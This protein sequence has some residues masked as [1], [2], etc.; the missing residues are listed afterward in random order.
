MI[1]RPF[2]DGGK[3]E[4]VEEQLDFL[5]VLSVDKAVD[6]V[7]AGDVDGVMVRVVGA[8]HRA[9]RLTLTQHHLVALCSSTPHRASA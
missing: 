8:R 4:V 7:V 9:P 5:E 6:V 2:G 1:Y 3:V